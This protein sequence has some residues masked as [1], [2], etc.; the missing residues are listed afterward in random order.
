MPVPSETELISFGNWTLRIRPAAS[1]PARLLLLLHGW[2]GDENSMWVF[3]AKFTRKYWVVAPRAPHVTK[4]SGFSWRMA[5]PEHNE[6]PEVED[7]QTSAEE[8]IAL[9]DQYAA[10]N[11]IAAGRFNLI[12]FSQGA[13][14]ANTLALMNPGRIER[15][16]I[17]AGFV[18]QGAEELVRGRPLDGKKFF[19]AH[20]SRDDMVR[21]EHAQLSVSLLEAAGAQVTFCEDDVGHKVGAGCL[22]ALENFFA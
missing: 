22:R 18:P 14:L 6:R 9:V 7:L 11:R 1:R 16:A 4:P 2:T 8:I 3:V 10:A 12:G 21:V 15:V 19:V 20:G 17:L 5:S 13:A